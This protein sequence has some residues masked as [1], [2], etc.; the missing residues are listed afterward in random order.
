M[1]NTLTETKADI[2]IRRRILNEWHRR[3]DVGGFDAAFEHPWMYAARLLVFVPS[4]AVG[5]MA[6]NG[7]YNT[8][9]QLAAVVFFTLSVL[10]VV[11][12]TSSL[13]MGD[14]QTV[15]SSFLMVLCV[16]LSFEAMPPSLGE[17]TPP[18]MEGLP[19]PW[20]TLGI[21]AYM[22]CLV[23]RRRT[24]WAWGTLCVALLFAASYG[25]RSD[26]GALSGVLSMCSLIGLI[27]AAQILVT[28]MRR[29]FTRRRE[30]WRMGLSARTTDEENQDLVNASI[31]RIQEVRRMAGGL[32]ER[33]AH[34][35]SPVTDYDIAQFRL[36]EAQL[37]DSI[38]GRAIANPRLLEVARNARERG[39]TVDILDERGTPLPH[40]I[41]EVV[42]DQAVAVLD[43]A[44]TGAVTIRAFSPDD[45]TAVF[46]VHDPGDEDSD[47][48]AIEIEQETGE[49]SVL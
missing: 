1:P 6:V 44:Q 26:V 40:R 41:M 19:S 42:T 17:A 23:V 37:R 30:A 2:G 49:I 43:A 3:R 15:T 39:V 24:G 29:L 31:R 35:N 8:S 22:V 33:I 12:P 34:D 27:L 4:I 16:S 18:A 5:L 38:R 46:I 28:E 13:R 14:L 11:W 21:H 10:L 25:A 32:L 36:T 7:S 47:A 48:V 9:A 45:A 20:Y